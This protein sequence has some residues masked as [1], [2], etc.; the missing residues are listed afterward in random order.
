MSTRLATGLLSFA[1]DV[2]GAWRYAVG[3]Q[4]N[5]RR[6]PATNRI[7]A[8]TSGFLAGP[9]QLAATNAEMDSFALDRRVQTV[10][11]TVQV[12]VEEIGIDVERHRRFGVAEHSLNCLHIR[13][14]TDCEAAFGASGY[15]T[16]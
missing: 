3:T 15:W 9:T 13:V 10:R 5:L 2:A 1:G 14:R 4:Q 12:L 6:L 7:N 16:L 11:Y 8:L